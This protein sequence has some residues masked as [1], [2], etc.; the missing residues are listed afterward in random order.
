MD[1]SKDPFYPVLM[2]GEIWTREMVDEYFRKRGT[3]VK[4]LHIQAANKAVVEASTGGG[5]YE[6]FQSGPNGK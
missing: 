5:K 1:K 4:V 3:F 6:A 2:S